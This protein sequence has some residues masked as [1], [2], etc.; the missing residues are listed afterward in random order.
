M[1]IFIDTKNETAS[2]IIFLKIQLCSQLQ[3]PPNSVRTY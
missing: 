3:G 1:D 2:I